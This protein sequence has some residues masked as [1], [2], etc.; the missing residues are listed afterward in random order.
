LLVDLDDL[1]IVG[2]VGAAPPKP[3]EL[4]SVPDAVK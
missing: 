1:G 4:W 2:R 3:Y